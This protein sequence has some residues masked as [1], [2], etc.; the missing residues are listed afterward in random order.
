MSIAALDDHAAWYAIR[1][2]PKEEDRADINLRNWQVQ[3]FTPKLREL[4]TSGYGGRQYVSKPLFAGYIFAHFDARK[5]LHDINYTRGVLNVVS[6]GGSFISI[7]DKVINLLKA[8]VDEDGFIK[9]DEDLKLG[10]KVRINSGPFASLIGIFKRTTK[11]NERVRILL[12]SMMCQSHL[13]IARRMV[14]KVN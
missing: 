3:T 1:T 6:F 11:D 9:M 10:D 8:R 4:R 5:L 13:L 7:D 2:K 12:D 14:E